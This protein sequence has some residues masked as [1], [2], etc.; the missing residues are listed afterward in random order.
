MTKN[1]RIDVVIKAREALGLD[2]PKCVDCLHYK[3][4]G[5]MS[6]GMHVCNHPMACSPTEFIPDHRWCDH[7]RSDRRD[8]GEYGRYFEA[9]K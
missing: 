7:N 6:L 2:P 9:K 3:Y 4:R 1:S 8:C 5:P